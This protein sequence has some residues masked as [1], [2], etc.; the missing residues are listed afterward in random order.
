MRKS[1][2]TLTEAIIWNLF[3]L[4]LLW[5]LVQT[6][7]YAHRISRPTHINP[8][9]NAGTGIRPVFFPSVYGLHN[10][11]KWLV[12]KCLREHKIIRYLVNK[13]DASWSQNDVSKGRQLPQMSSSNGLPWTTTPPR[14]ECWCM[15][16]EQCHLCWGIQAF[17]TTRYCKITPHFLNIKHFCRTC[18]SGC[19][20]GIHNCYFYTHRSNANYRIMQTSVR[21]QNVHRPAVHHS[22][23]KTGL[24]N[25]RKVLTSSHFLT[26]PSFPADLCPFGA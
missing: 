17:Y 25:K 14:W 24:F 9:S 26:L 16:T 5:C 6:C 15:Q 21:I 18:S 7:S 23:K 11:P 4:F 3:W 13:T 19:A 8:A 10:A 2:S 12:E 1:E 22:L 20:C